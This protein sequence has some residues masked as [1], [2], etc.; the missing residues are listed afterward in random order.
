MRYYPMKRNNFVMTFGIGN[1][2]LE[3]DSACKTELN[4]SNITITKREEQIQ[5]SN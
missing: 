4:F 3:N 2:K 5:V 1:I